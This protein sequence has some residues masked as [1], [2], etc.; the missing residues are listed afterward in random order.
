MSALRAQQ[1]FRGT[2]TSTNAA[3]IKC[4]AQTLSRVL[5]TELDASAVHASPKQIHELLTLSPSPPSRGARACFEQPR[6]SW[7]LCSVVQFPWQG[8]DPS[9]MS[10]C[11]AVTP[12]SDMACMLYF[13]CF[14]L[15]LLF[16]WTLSLEEPVPIAA[17]S[18]LVRP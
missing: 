16:E 9:N 14:V 4:A 17:V 5:S 13:I 1:V 15:A 7:E 18:L 2:G 6:H 8:C 12:F 3:G 11:G 10:E